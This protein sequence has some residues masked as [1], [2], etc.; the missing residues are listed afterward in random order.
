MKKAE[1]VFIPI[2][3]RGHLLSMV[4]FAKLLVARDPHLYV[5][6]LIM[7]LPFD[8]MVG[9]YTASLVSSSSNRINCI[10]LPINEKVY[11]E[12]NPPVFMTSFIEDQKPHVKNAVTQL[13]QS[14]DVDDEDSPRLAGFVIDMFCTTMIDV[15][16]EFGIPT[17]VFFA[18]GAGFLGLLF[19]LQHLSDNHNVN[20][21]E[22]E[23]DPEAELVIP[24]F[25]NPFPSKVLP[26]LVLDKDGGPVMMNHARRIRETKGII[27]NTFTELESHAVYSLSNGDHEFPP[28][29]PVGPILNLRSD[30]S[31]VGSVN[32]IQNS[33]IIRWLDNQPPSSVVF[34]CFGS[35]GS[36]SEDQV[37]EIAYGLEQSG[38]RF[39]WSLRPPPPKDKMGLP[40]DY[41]DPTV[42]LP[43]G[44]LGRTAEV[45]KVIGWAPQVEILSHSAT[46]GFVSHCGWNSTLESLWFGVPIATWPIF[47]EQQLNAFQMVKE[48]GCAVEIKLD[49][50][51]EF[52]SD[53]DDQA[54]VSAQEIERGIRRVMDDDS[55][56]RKRTKEISEQSRRTLV[57]GGTSF[58]CL[59]HLINDILKNVS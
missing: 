11:T 33:D 26:V 47:A 53:G 30:E 25:V 5:T 14:R 28:V 10:D 9:A 29:Y 4:E 56:I 15:A 16:N 51:R 24:S 45:G 35:M 48:F 17:Y 34:V 49:Y 46:G 42:V 38:Q 31:H 52:N 3:G 20:I 36:F 1:L 58:S 32:Q 50:R 39:I 19:H 59:G 55:D 27:V 13:I 54:V 8:T 23:N 7:K 41:L 18:S 22:Y 21:T 37:K 43:E 40:S 6:I 2:P 57:D 44:F 12:S